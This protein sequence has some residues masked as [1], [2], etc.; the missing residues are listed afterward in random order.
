MPDTPVTPLITILLLLLQPVRPCAVTT[1]DGLTFQLGSVGPTTFTYLDGFSYAF[2]VCGDL[3]AGTLG[4]A[5]PAPLVQADSLGKCTPLGVREGPRARAWSPR[6][7]KGVGVE[8]FFGAVPESC[9]RSSQLVVVCDPEAVTAELQRPA[10]LEVRLC[11][12]NLTVRSPA[13]CPVQCPRSADG[14]VCGGRAR[15]ACELGEGGGGGAHCACTPGFTGV[16]CEGAVEELAGSQPQLRTDPPR[17]GAA[18]GMRAGE[19]RLLLLVMAV[20]LGV[21][22]ALD[23]ACEARCAVAGKPML[24]PSA[25]R[26]FR[27]TLFTAALLLC[28]AVVPQSSIAGVTAMEGQ[29]FSSVDAPPP[30]LAVQLCGYGGIGAAPSPSPSPPTG[31]SAVPGVVNRFS[32]I[33]KGNLWGDLGGGSGMGSTLEATSTTR[34]I[35]EMLVYRYGVRSLLDAPCGS[36]HWWPPLLRSI[37]EVIPC[38]RYRGVDIVA[39][40]IAASSAQWRDDELTTFAVADVS[41]QPLGSGYDMVLCRDAL[42]HLP[43]ALAVGVLANIAST[44]PRLLLVGSYL[45]ENDNRDVAIGDYYPVNVVK[46]PFILPEPEAVFEE[47]VPN[48]GPPT[49]QAVKFLLLYTAEQLATVDWDEMKTRVRNWRRA[50]QW[51]KPRQGSA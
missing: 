5:S 43:L 22:L 38:F 15:G 23:F 40:V 26:C 20:L 14:A 21:A 11:K 3:P 47:K 30:S 29:V 34:V 37:R 4:C 25:R 33:Y 19:P 17:G 24:S 46:W 49:N 41:Q 51:S 6:R 12:Y 36:S 39:S 1:A 13:G 50:L 45:T 16:S 28:A 44:H 7:G 31:G 48:T 35:V 42:Q 8:L 2:N 18:G 27:M 9:G 10:A 32:E